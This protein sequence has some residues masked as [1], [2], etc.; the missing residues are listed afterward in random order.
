MP[1]ES[2][3]IG[4][5]PPSVWLFSLLPIAGAS[6]PFTT[7]A[8]PF[9]LRQEGVSVERIG[10]IVTESLLVVPFSF[11]A[12]PVADMILPRR[13]WV[14]VGNLVGSLLLV[15]AILLPRP[16]ALDWL[17]V[18]LA[19][20]NVAIFLGIMG[21]L[22]LMA[23]VLPDE[24]RGRASG[25]FQLGNMGSIP[26]LGGACL[27]I[28]AH[29]T[30]VSGAVT[31]GLMSFLPALSAFFVPEPRRP[32]RP[33]LAMY[34]GMLG[35]LADLLRQR[36]AWLGI[37]LFVAPLGS[38]ALTALLSGL[39]VDYH[40]G[41]AVVQRVTGIPGGVIAAVIGAYIGGIYS[42]RIP[43]RKAYLGT[44]VLLV[45]AGLVLAL[46]PLTPSTYVVGGL[47]YEMANAMAFAASTAL[48]LEITES[49]PH[50]AAFRMALYTAC[51]NLPVSY[52]PAIDGWG[53]RWGVRG[54]AGT[55]VAL[56]LGSVLV[57]GLIALRYWPTA[58]PAARATAV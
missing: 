3:E 49:A 29:M 42:D 55:D 12:A 43:R 31:I 20:A 28:S 7:V 30:R 37:L 9:L 6:Y 40:A 27:L 15:V 58:R 11:V 36:C 39:G 45:L 35:E 32:L 44:A 54:V 17:P 23:A 10:A 57:C 52:M 46:G 18:V 16:S 34:R 22:G 5:R 19:L 21:A 38:G 50:T 53:N 2:P 33:S 8:L 1:A 47:L 26:F 41:A 25:W 51:M 14:I 56:G 24:V 4:T 48:A 13:H